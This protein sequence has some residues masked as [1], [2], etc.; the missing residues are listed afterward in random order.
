MRTPRSTR[1]STWELSIPS[2]GP[3][4]GAN[5][6]LLPC[7]LHT[8]EIASIQGRP[9][10]PIRRTYGRF[11]RYSSRILRKANDFRQ[12]CWWLQRTRTISLI[13]S[14]RLDIMRRRRFM[15]LQPKDEFLRM[16]QRLMKMELKRLLVQPWTS[17]SP[18]TSRDCFGSW[19]M[20]LRPR[21]EWM[22][23]GTRN[24]LAKKL[25]AD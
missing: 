3:H 9:Q 15:E 23:N 18:A 14:G 16:E 12:K 13:D 21:P 11:W 25:R 5:H 10:S 2:I 6:I 24:K 19:P 1:P 17:S 20:N 7:I 4:P 8:Y 22:T